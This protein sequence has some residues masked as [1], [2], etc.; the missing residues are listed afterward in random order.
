M[1]ADA[2]ESPKAVDDSF[3]KEL[4]AWGPGVMMESELEREQRVQE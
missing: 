4:L 2:E 3:I 1:I